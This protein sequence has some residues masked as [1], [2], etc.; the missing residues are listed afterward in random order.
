MCVGGVCVLVGCVCDWFRCWELLVCVFVCVVF[1]NVCMF[2]GWCTVYGVGGCV[3]LV[4][5]CVR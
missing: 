5:V 3:S 1:V 4:C 2:G